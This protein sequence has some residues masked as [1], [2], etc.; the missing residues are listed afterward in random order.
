MG[1]FWEGIPAYLLPVIARALGPGATSVE[2][3]TFRGD[4]ALLFANTFGSCTT[5][6]RSEDIGA[7]AQARF[8]GDARVRVLIGSSRELLADALPDRETPCFVWLDA[9]GVYD[10]TGA[11]VEENPL[12]A[13]LNI[14]GDARN[15]LNTVIAIDDARGMGTQPGWPSISAISQ[16]L[17]AQGYDVIFLDDILLA[18][19]SQLGLDTYAIYKASRQVEVPMVFHVWSNINRLVRG[20]RTL[21]TVV[22]RVRR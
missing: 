14:I 6:E 3:G 12:L 10:L 17:V 18:F 16:A 1:Y 9:H 8:A 11:D 22:S 19:D 20:R 4:S 13:E 15:S 21:D 5:I 2:T 7:Q